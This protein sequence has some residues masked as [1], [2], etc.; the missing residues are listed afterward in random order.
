M[1]KDI[2]PNNL[3]PMMKQYYDI[4]KQYM[5]T[6]LLYRLGDFYEMFFDDALTASK[7]LE[8]VL[9]QRECGLEKKAPMAGIPH[10]TAKPYISKL[11]DNGFRVAICEQLEDP[12]KAK[13]LVKRGVVRIISPGMNLDGDESRSHNYLMSIYLEK[14]L[15][16]ISYIDITT[17]HIYLSEE[18]IDKSGP[19]QT[20]HD[21]IAK[22][23][24]SEILINTFDDEDLDRYFLSQKSIFISKYKK[25]DNNPD[26]IMS[27][28]EKY[29]SKKSIKDFRKNHLALNS[30]ASLLDYIYTY[31]KT[32]LQHFKDPV[33]VDKNEY[34]YLDAEARKNLDISRN[35]DHNTSLI[36][37]LDIAVS[38]MGSRL[39]ESSVENPLL[40]K[41]EIEQRLDLVEGFYMDLDLVKSIRGYLDRVHDVER[42]LGRLAYSRANA[43]DLVSLKYSIEPL[44]DIKSCLSQS[45][46]K[47]IRILGDRLD[48]LEDIFDL[49][50]KSIVEEPPVSITEGSMIK[51]G[52]SKKLDEIR[53]TSIYGRKRLGEYEEEQR[54]VSG[55]KNLKIIHNKNTGYFLDVTKS[56]LDKIPI[57]Y[58]RVQTLTNSER[59]MTEELK[60]IENMIFTSTDD[61]FSL[62]Y[63]IFNEIKD[64]ITSQASRIQDMAES[65]AMIDMAASFAKL[66][67]DNKYVKPEFI[68]GKS[69]DIKNARHPMVEKS[70]GKLNFIPNDID[71][72]DENL[73][74]IITGPNMSGK[75]TYLRQLAIIVLMAQIGSFVPADSARLPIVDKIFTRIGSSDN[76]IR[77]ESTFMVEMKEMAHI[78]NNATE[79]S[80]LL[81]D[82]VGRGTSTYDGISIAWAILEY[83]SKEI[84][85]KTLF[86]T[87]YQELVVLADRL[88][89]AENYS[90]RVKEDTSGIVFLYKI[91]KGSASRSFGIEVAKLSGMA[92]PII[93]RAR[94]ILASIE[95]SS[96]LT[97]NEEKLDRQLDFYSQQR[98]NL[99]SQIRAID[100]NNLSPLDALKELDSIIKNANLLGDN[101]D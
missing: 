81:L 82:E 28:L 62:E 83:L 2:D 79:R 93:D 42:I 17:G 66:A 37:L 72:E 61:T 86:A 19:V 33:Y 38:P 88:E 31:E 101:Y 29:L 45:E 89:N 18:R 48:T 75:S 98:E 78:I 52:Y 71:M 44:A 55:I 76:I 54:Q 95:A 36:D 99:L 87:H 4:K 73:I 16:G 68:D 74:Q 32:K 14:S 43:R 94:T 40:S 30:L 35:K 13:G 34:M 26:Q 53:E 41:K 57:D 10:H 56:N 12:S 58:H 25:S 6:I 15:I 21:Q 63:D 8:I 23:K 90:I 3:T 47:S 49:L 11:I 20:I 64:K 91:E 97:V 100:I 24:P 60:E 1:L 84:G 9:T 5:D 77:G 46:D 51:E 67:L 59:F 96:S 85:A 27:F 69:L 7:I 65:L 22:V 50:D 70:I 92:K 39:I 80:L